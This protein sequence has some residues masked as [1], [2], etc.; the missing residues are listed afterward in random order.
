MAA[1]TLYRRTQAG[2]LAWQAQDASVPLEYRKVLGLIDG[3]IHPDSLRQR[4]IRHS[5][6]EMQYLLDELVEHG[7]LE[8]IPAS[9]HHDLDFTGDFDFSDLAKK[10]AKR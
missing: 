2:K 9:E 8:A 3:E 10:A 6:T 5:E 7:L 4:L 1:E